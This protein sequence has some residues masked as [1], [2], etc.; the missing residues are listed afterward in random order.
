MYRR[1]ATVEPQTPEEAVALREL[2]ATHRRRHRSLALFCSVTVSVHTTIIL[3]TIWHDWPLDTRAWSAILDG[4]VT[5]L[6]AAA[7]LFQF[8]TGPIKGFAGTLSLG[9]LANRFTAV[10]VCEVVFDTIVAARPLQ[11][12]SV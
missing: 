7:M 9:L 8:G 5:T 2:A 3:H 10:F 12:L 11:R 6:I 4:N 1:P